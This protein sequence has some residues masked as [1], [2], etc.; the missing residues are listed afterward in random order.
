MTRGKE[1]NT[2]A[3]K[4]SFTLSYMRGVGMGWKRT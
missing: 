3:S 2:V 1:F 4:V